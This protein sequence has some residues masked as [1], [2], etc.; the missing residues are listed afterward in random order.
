M[1]VLKSRL[2]RDGAGRHAAAAIALINVARPKSTTP[3]SKGS[4]F[5]SAI[6]DPIALTA[7]TET[8]PDMQGSGAVRSLREAAS[9]DTDAGRALAAKLADYAAA[10][11]Q[12]AQQALLPGLV[13]AWA[14]TSSQAPRTGALATLGYFGQ[15]VNG[16]WA[17]R[18][19]ASPLDPA[20]EN[21][22][23]VMSDL[24]VAEAF[25]GQPLSTQ[26]AFDSSG[27]LLGAA[28]W[29]EQ[30]GSLH[31]TRQTIEQSVYDGLVLQ[32][33]LKPYLDAIALNITE[34]GIGL[35]YSGVVERLEGWDAVNGAAWVTRRG[36]KSRRWR[37]GGGVKGSARAN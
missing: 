15:W 30:L 13:E 9:L 32:T 25:N 31:L 16:E 18:V 6:S 28:L 23:Q 11:T 19:S 27:E 33:R 20:S 12:A 24:N 5:F 22:R 29:S 7:Q 4:P 37:D 34:S 21:Y 2:W 14:A 1:Q 36:V 35:D 8:L 10:S 17:V 26:D 3:L